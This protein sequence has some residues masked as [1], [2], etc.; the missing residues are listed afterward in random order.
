MLVSLDGVSVGVPEPSENAGERF[1]GAGGVKVHEL[2]VICLVVL[3]LLLLSMLFG[4]AFVESGMV[5]LYASQDPWSRLIPASVILIF[6]GQ[7]LGEVFLLRL[8][9]RGRLS[10]LHIPCRITSLGLPPL[11]FLLC[12]QGAFASKYPWNL[13]FTGCQ[14]LIALLLLYD[15]TLSA[16]A[17]NLPL[18]VYL[19]FLGTFL[20][21]LSPPL[22]VLAT[23]LLATLYDTYSVTRGPLK[24]LAKTLKSIAELPCSTLCVGR[25]QLGLGDVLVYSML[26]PVFLLHPYFS[27][28]R[29][30][31][32]SA[33]LLLGLPT[34]AVVLRQ[35]KPA[36]G[37]ALPVTFSLIAYA[38]CVQIGA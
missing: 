11:F 13:V 1:S 28:A 7:P 30:A 21:I 2:A 24:Q 29:W 27:A 34:T 31:A 23:A 33:A 5:D 8:A 36:S 25:R 15:K 10:T 22:L 17:P 37:L 4:C 9:R 6:A 26:S 32:A 14:L 19:T 16:A 20:G 12:M 3:S 18:A 38:L 35:W